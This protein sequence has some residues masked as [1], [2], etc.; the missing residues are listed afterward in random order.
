MFRH[1]IPTELWQEL[2]AEGLLAAEAAVSDH[3]ENPA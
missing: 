3:E 1:P 2:T